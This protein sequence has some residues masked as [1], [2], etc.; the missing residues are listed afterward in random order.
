MK[1]RTKL[2]VYSYKKVGKEEFVNRETKVKIKYSR[3]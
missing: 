2:K 1:K 3:V